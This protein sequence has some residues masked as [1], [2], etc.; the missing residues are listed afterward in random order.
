MPART[1]ELVFPLLLERELGM[2]PG[3]GV[4]AL[5]LSRIFDLLGLVLFFLGALALAGSSANW[6]GDLAAPIA[7]GLG[8]L[9]VVLIACFSRLVDLGLTLAERVASSRVGR[10]KLVRALLSATRSASEAAAAAGSPFSVAAA[11]GATVL[12]WFGIFGCFWALMRP[13]GLDPIS[14][15]LGASSAALAGALPVNGIGAFGSHEAG[16]TFGFTLLGLES[17][18]ALATGIMTN[19]IATLFALALGGVS[20]IAHALAGAHGSGGE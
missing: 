8:A 1:G 7:V 16:W 19:V 10:F 15:I 11:L 12:V 9:L 3:K 5:V 18:R 2:D 17:S 14:V 6:L 4:A 20:M 13:E